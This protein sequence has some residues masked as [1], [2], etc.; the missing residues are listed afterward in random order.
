VLEIWWWILVLL[1]LEKV[2]YGITIEKINNAILKTFLI[3]EVKN[4]RKLV[5]I[6][7]TGSIL[8]EC[9]IRVSMQL[10]KN[11]APY[12]MVCIV[13]FIAPT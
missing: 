8:V 4:G 9:R 2:T 13:V 10:K 11:L 6:E 1:N 12:L 3:I 5:S 7:A